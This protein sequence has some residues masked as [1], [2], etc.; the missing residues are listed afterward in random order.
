MFVN[1]FAMITDSQYT[2]RVSEMIVKQQTEN[3]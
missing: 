2:F 3:I 1:D